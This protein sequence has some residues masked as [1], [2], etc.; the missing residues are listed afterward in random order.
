MRWGGTDLQASVRDLER[1]NGIVDLCIDRGLFEYVASNGDDSLLKLSP[2][3]AN[4][5]SEITQEPAN[6]PFR[7]LEFPVQSVYLP[8]KLIEPRGD[9]WNRERIS[10]SASGETGFKPTI[11][12]R[13]SDLFWGKVL[14]AELQHYNKRPW[15]DRY[16]DLV[17]FLETC[18]PTKEERSSDQKDEDWDITLF[19]FLMELSAVAQGEASYG[20]A[21]RARSLV[22]K[23]YNIEK[24]EIKDDSNHQRHR[25]DRWIWYNMGLAYQHIGRNQ[26]AIVEYD[27]VISRFFKHIKHIKSNEYAQND[28]IV[29][30]FLLNIFPSTLQR[31]AV[32]LKLQM[33]Y[34]ALQ[35]LADSKTYKFITE[36]ADDKAELFKE[37]AA[38]LKHSSVLL[39]I[40]ALLQ[41]ERSE[42]ARDEL[43]KIYPKIFLGQELQDY[44]LPSPPN[45]EDG[46]WKPMQT[47]L[48]EQTVFWFL[49]KKDGPNGLKD[50]VKQLEQTGK[51]VG[52]EQLRT[53]VVDNIPKIQEI[54]GRCAAIS[55]AI[56]TEYWHWVEGNPFDERIYLSRWAKFLGLTANCLNTMA[57]IEK[58]SSGAALVVPNGLN[59]SANKLIE[60]SLKLYC[61][62]A[63]DRPRKM[64]DLANLRSDDLPEFVGGLSSYYKTLSNILLLKDVHQDQ[65]IVRDGPVSA[66]REAFRKACNSF[67]QV[68]DRHFR[69]TYQDNDLL[70]LLKQDHLE[71]L[72]ALD[73]HDREFG[74]NQKI[75]SLKRCNERLIWIDDH[76]CRNL[77]QKPCCP[78]H[79][80]SENAFYGLLECAG[81]YSPTDRTVNSTSDHP[82]R[83]DY[84]FIM[85]EAEEGLTK[86][87]LKS[88]QPE[89]KEHAL[90][91]FGL[92]RWNSLT[93]AQGRS[94]GGGYFIYRTN[95]NF[96]VDL[97][98]AI[99]PGFDFVRNLFRMGFTLRDIDI[100]LISHAHPD[101]LW[102]FE[103][104]VQLLKELHDKK[105]I[106]H[107]L[108]VVLTLGIYK[109]LQHVIGN[110]ELRRFLDPLVIDSRKELEP[111]FFETLGPKGDK[112]DLNKKC[113]IFFDKTEDQDN[114]GPAGAMQV[115]RWLPALPGIA[116]TNGSRGKAE[117]EIWPTRAYHD[118][119]SQQ[120]DSFGFLIR[121]TDIKSHCKKDSPLCVGYTGDTKWVHDDLYNEGCPGK[122]LNVSPCNGK[123]GRSERSWKG[124]ACQYEE[125]DVLL[126]HIG[127]LIQ[128]KDDKRFKNYRSFKDCESMMRKVNHPYLMGI[129]RFLRELRNNVGKS[130]EKL[131][132]IG[133][134]GE[135]LRGGIRTDI[136]RRLKQEIVKDWPVLPVDVGMDILL[137]DYCF[138]PD[139]KDNEKE[140]FKFLCAL[141]G[142][143]HKLDKI[144]YIRFG[145]DEAIFNVCRTCKKAVPEDVRYTKLQRLYEIGRELQTKEG[146]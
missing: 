119:Y 4:F 104:L 70:S 46:I 90:H 15:V 82:D 126:M 30:E 117:I 129:M 123:C 146:T 7:K 32:N 39:R 37:A 27:R 127:S 85:S 130:K 139:K 58:L 1:I 66:A 57:E 132:L 98:I 87:L 21:E 41:L 47:Q 80:G 115:M 59:E 52:R 118:D 140:P 102:D 81:E 128:H 141:C 106:T 75:S 51:R 61:S 73:G 48:I 74:Q 64:I 13:W 17:L 49:E 22:Q 101:H 19:C 111:D 55:S 97:G 143:Y 94:V 62:R 145:R 86:H 110:P 84:Q 89:P 38:D 88:S 122:T 71:L 76:V 6:T 137:H 103:S 63:D 34:H 24:E 29:L 120:S 33:A 72:D 134:F 124:L 100:V 131:I 35:T 60:C 42:E 83:E 77:S 36:L 105:G 69:S 109:R 54:V 125:C 26:K 96:V 99:D 23:L 92:Q 95:K 56:Q 144:D 93:P 78:R 11:A 113:F 121:F 12:K 107:R 68:T 16:D 20:Y 65:D 9:K 18:L 138:V 10:L 14:R 142:H 79:I 3:A 50:L 43:A 45:E 116:R 108:N 40:E 91:F 112:K 135:E 53:E 31:A 5:I 25:Y 136:V 2:D 44:S 28:D 114:K 67:D 8:A 133:E